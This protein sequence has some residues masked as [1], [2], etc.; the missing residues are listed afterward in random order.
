MIIV[1]GV[2]LCGRKKLTY[3]QKENEYTTDEM[4]NE[5]GDNED[6]SNKIS[7]EEN[8]QPETNLED[9]K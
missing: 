9:N 3:E 4:P 7:F 5:I 2:L 1:I 8:N 6:N